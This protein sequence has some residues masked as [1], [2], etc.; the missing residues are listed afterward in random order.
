MSELQI[1]LSVAVLYFYLGHIA[2]VFLVRMWYSGLYVRQ[3]FYHPKYVKFLFVYMSG[4]FWVIYLPVSYF[5]YRKM[6]KN[7]DGF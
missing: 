5:H 3:D 2:Q 7:L 1:W 4:V 6:I